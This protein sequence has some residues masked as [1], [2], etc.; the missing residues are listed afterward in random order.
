[1]ANPLVILLLIILFILIVSR[2]DEF[3]KYMTSTYEPK[4]TNE[5]WVIIRPS[6]Y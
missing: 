3:M 5:S 1:M 2:L 6:R 4:T